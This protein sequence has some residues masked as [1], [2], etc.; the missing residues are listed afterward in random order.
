V[1][2]GKTQKSAHWGQRLR[3]VSW[4]QFITV[5]AA[6]FVLIQMVRLLWTLLVP[7]TP[8]GNWQATYPSNIS[9]IQR[10]ELFKG[11][12]PFFRTAESSASTGNITALAL[13]LFGIR[14]N[15][16]SGGGSAIIADAKGIQHSYATGDEI[17]PGVTL[18]AVAFDHVVISNNGV[19]EQIYMDQSVPATNVTPP[20]PSPVN[21]PAPFDG[22]P[23][24][25]QSGAAIPVSA[26]NE[27][28]STQP[29]LEG[30][31]VTGIVISSKGDKDKFRSLGFNDG[32]IITSINGK[33]IGSAADLF[34]Q[35]KPG[36]KLAIGIE[37]GGQD[38]PLAL[39]LEP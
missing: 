14:S 36:A 24:Q 11:F 21:K 35:I 23:N 12:D 17:M 8:V 16:A 1:A 18:H 9:A 37:R 28:V 7:V 10:K 4:F 27:R 34:A 31:K 3:S 19:L 26:L 25:V 29:R 13:V 22:T 32:D 38:V 5:I 20:E 30:G 39:S 15:E 6:I 33:P 2:L